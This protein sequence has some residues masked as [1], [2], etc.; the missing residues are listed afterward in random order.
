[1]IAIERIDTIIERLE[2]I[3]TEFKKTLGLQFSLP[4][5]DEAKFLDTAKLMLTMLKPYAYVVRN[6]ADLIAGRPDVEVVLCGMYI[7]L[8]L[9]RYDGKQRAAQIETAYEIVEANGRYVTCRTLIEIYSTLHD[10]LEDLKKSL[11]S[12]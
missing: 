2:R 9:K 1:M 12:V 3:G 10:T 5:R 4:Y 8:E 7:G 6:N 11:L